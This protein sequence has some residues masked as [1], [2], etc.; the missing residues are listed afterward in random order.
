MRLLPHSVRLVSTRPHALC[1]CPQFRVLQTSRWWRAKT[2]RGPKRQ[3]PSAESAPLGFGSR[4]TSHG[5]RVRAW[6]TAGTGIDANHVMGSRAHEPVEVERGW[7]H[8]QAR[9]IPLPNPTAASWLSFVSVRRRLP[10]DRVS[11]VITAGEPRR[12]P[13]KHERP[14]RQSGIWNPDMR[15][16]C[17]SGRRLESAG[18]TW[19]AGGGRD[20]GQIHERC[21]MTAG[22]ASI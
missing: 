8:R 19:Y 7:T 20:R 6:R 21:R 1:V 3:T 17:A 18:T 14:V 4:S 15:G 9:R 10:R 13:W 2:Y 22:L 5:R 16:V 12:R 11:S